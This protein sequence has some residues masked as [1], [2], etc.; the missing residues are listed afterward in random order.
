MTQSKYKRHSRGG[1]FRQQWEGSRAAVDEI[2]RQR[3]TEIDA[4]K[5][6]AL[7]QKER[8]SLQI[9]GLR[10]VAKN[11]AE[12]RGILQ[13]L[14]NKIYQNKRNAISVR[15]QTEVDSILGEANELGKEAKF[16]EEFATKH[17]KEL[18][19]AA[20]NLY[21]FAQYRAAIKAYEVG[22]LVVSHD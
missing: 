17:S 7:Q 22:I 10:N 8:D 1:R 5:T 3:Q 15:S 14:E 20:G 13:D 6:Q 21:N 12:N 16:W 9:S 18:G 11:E 19:T 2:R 4:L